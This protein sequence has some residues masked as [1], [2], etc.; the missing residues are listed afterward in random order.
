MKH[1][2]LIIL[3]TLGILPCFLLSATLNVKQ[4]GSGDYITI[5]AAINAAAE[6]DTIL[7]YPGRYHE[8]IEIMDKKLSI[9]SL[10]MITA[11]S[12]Y[13]AQTII[14]GDHSGSCF[15][16]RFSE[17]S[18]RGFY[19]TNGAG[20]FTEPYS[21]RQGGAI[22]TS[23]SKL[24]IINCRMIDNKAYYCGGIYVN[25]GSIFLAGTI[26]A[27]NRAKAG[28]A[29]HYVGYTPGED[30]LT[31]DP[32]NRCSIYNN[33]SSSYNDIAIITSAFESIDI[34]L[35]KFTVDIDSEY[36]KECF[37]AYHSINWLLDL[38]F[39][40]NEAVLVQQAAD[41]YVSP[42]GD[43]E[44][45]GL[46]PASPLKSIDKAIH[47]IEADADNPRIIH[48]AN[49]YY[50]DEQHF[51]LN[52]RSYVSLIGES[53]SGVVFEGSE[54]FL[55]GWDTEKE[56]MIKNITFTGTI[57]NGQYFWRLID[58]NHN[59]MFV[60][61]VLD[62]PSFHLENLSFRKVRPVYNDKAFCLIF[63]SYPEKFILRN[64]TVE[65][66]EY[67]SGFYLWGA[68]VDA[69][70][71]TFKNNPNPITRPVE[72][73][74][75]A[76]YTNNPIATGG[77]SFYRNVSIT[78][79]HSRSNGA[80]G[81]GMIRITHS[82][83]ST[84]FRNYFI[85]CTIADNIWDTGY[86]SVVNMEDDAKATFINSIISYD[87]GTAFMLNH[88][89]VTMPVH[90]QI[91]NCLLGNSGSLENQVY[92][93]WDL[94]EVE[95][96]G[97]NMT[98]DPGFYAWEPE[99]PYTLGQDSPCIDAG[100]TDL[101]ELNMSSFYEFPA[102]D[103]AGNPR[104]YGD[105]I[106]LGAYEWQGQ[107]GVEDLVESPI[108][109]ISNYPNPFNPETTISY[110]IAKAAKVKLDIYNL[111]GQ[112]VKTLVNK[113]L[114]AGSHSVNWDGKDM[115]DRSV[116]SGVYFYRLTTPDFTQSKKM[117]MMK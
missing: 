104:I 28:A 34:Y 15:N 10:E 100:T 45:S 112:L 3:F 30:T 85:N 78:N 101:R 86:G 117:I 54:V 99:H 93:T 1:K 90:L 115:N 49:G 4:D 109:S 75:I 69:D 42:D 116:S 40:Y 52:L 2:I 55:R 8:N 97:T 43:D 39:Y 33:Q 110:S 91:M 35:D 16:V 84:D 31:F 17:I 11:D 56:V 102:Y 25:Y 111:K 27:N 38:N 20:T 107:V 72:G 32:D 46:S 6:N 5:Q 83:A 24:D 113:E 57:N 7:V 98:G 77:D 63:V 81:S 92:S 51:P 70:N 106:D 65:N 14:D 53:E 59:S 19:M 62:K 9:G 37:R 89:S 105:E 76:I 18:L 88:T 79:C 82:H 26:V 95:W 66:C 94:N 48:L 103:L 114:N 21:V 108:I 50:G 36:F 23:Y 80:S 22:Y 13:I 44:N 12:T 61:G 71:I 64:I 87:R 41:L 73:G 47:R 29:L 68:N 96:Y 60:D 74:A 67:H 58:L